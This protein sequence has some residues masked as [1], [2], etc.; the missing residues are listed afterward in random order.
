MRKI[1]IGNLTETDLE[2]DP[3]E[4]SDGKEA[5]EKIPDWKDVDMIMCDLIMPRMDGI[6]FIRELRKK[7]DGNHV[8]IIVVTTEGSIVRMEEAITEGANDYIVKPFTG[9]ELYSRIKNLI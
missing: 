9:E 8:P 6:Q 7:T 2:F 4:A 3:V 1:I 5:L